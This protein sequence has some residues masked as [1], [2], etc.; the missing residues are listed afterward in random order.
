M[1][2]DVLCRWLAR[3]GADELCTVP[4]EAFLPLLAHAGAHGIRTVTARHEG[5]AGFMAVATARM[6]GRPGVV[7]VNRSPGSTNAAIAVDAA[8]ADP[9]PL[10]VLVGDIPTDADR[11]TAF[12][13][14]D[15]AGMFG[16]LATT[17]TLDPA[18]L[19]DQLARAA[20]ELAAPRPVVLL[21]PEDRWTAPVSAE[22]PAVAP[23]AAEVD[24]DDLRRELAAAER[25]VLLAGR[26][27][28][29]RH[30]DRGASDAL[31]ALARAAGLPV[32]VGNK[33]QDLLDNRDPHYAGHL[34]LGTPRAVRERLARADLVVFLGEKPDE[35]HTSGWSGPRVRVVDDRPARAVLDVLAAAS[36]PEAPPVRRE[37]LRGW[38]AL[39]EELASPRPRPFEDGVDFT[40]VAA[41][42][43]AELPADAV[44]TFD[45][46]NFSSWVHRYVHA[47]PSRLVLAL[48]NGAMGFGVPAAVS[49]A[50]RHPERTVVAL[51]GDGGLLMTGDELATGR[52]QGRCPVVVVADNGG[53]GTI[54]QH[55]R[56]Q[57]PGRYCGTSLHTPNLVTWAE[58]F[59]IPG[60]TVRGPGEVVGAVRR[61]LAAGPA[62]YLLHVRTSLRSGHANNE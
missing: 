29:S 30:T 37:W 40:H 44:L 22:P 6:T 13:G 41:A 19:A 25:P 14:A 58:S 56:R 23:A 16:A 36:W 57:F 20:E 53:Y 35:V 50:H 51:V 33:Q 15:L 9:T 8:A 39:A 11:R 32:L 2:V 49:V 26:L 52:A 21:V 62:G 24:A 12:Q 48:G 45:A 43:D 61:A 1:L 38:H 10:V 18:C 60:E 17:I 4:G 27:L 47:G 28:R 54:D 42:L 31:A 7:A 55:A 34:H 3:L 46:G 59:G 5:G